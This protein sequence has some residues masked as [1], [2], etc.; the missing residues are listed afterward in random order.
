MSRTVPVPPAVALALAL[1]GCPDNVKDPF[2]KAVGYQPLTSCVTADW[3]TDPLNPADPY[4]EMLS[5]VRAPNCGGSL[6]A[7]EYVVA[8]H[9]HARGFLKFPILAVWAKL[10]DPSWVHLCDAG[11][12]NGCVDSWR[13]LPGLETGDFPVSFR[14]AYH[15]DATLGIN[16]DWEHT[17]REGP[18]EG[19][20]EAP[21]AVGARYQKTWGIENIRVQTGSFVLRPTDTDPNVTSI[22]LVGWLDAAQSNE[23]TV[24]G[25]LTNAYELLRAGLY[26]PP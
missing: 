10:Q 24:A 18:L 9:A 16:V 5:V 8:D 14:I 2:P 22:E 20:V 21:L 23:N 6:N 12:S 17:W 3:P 11:Y 19:T 13:Y 1:A 4:P 25:T 7:D 15:V 26:A